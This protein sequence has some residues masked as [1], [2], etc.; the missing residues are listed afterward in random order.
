MI[1]VDR[2]S[3]SD[4]ILGIGH[5]TL[6]P[7]NYDNEAEAARAF[8]TWTRREERAGHFLYWSVHLSQKHVL[9][10]YPVV[11]PILPGCADGQ[12]TAANCTRK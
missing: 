10:C 2:C 7:E 8:W 9:W 12:C 3:C 1:V 6:R 4:G 5:N 11:V